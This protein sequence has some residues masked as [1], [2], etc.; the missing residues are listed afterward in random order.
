MPEGEILEDTPP[1]GEAEQR[2]L[3][4][5]V[6]TWHAEGRAHDSPF[7]SA[8]KISATQSYEWLPGERFLVHF[9]QGRRGEDA[10]ACIEIMAYDPPNKAYLVHSFYNDGHRNILQAVEHQGTWT[11][12]GGWR[13][14]GSTLKL[15][16]TSRFEDAG[17]TLASTWEYSRDGSR[18]DCFWETRAVRLPA[19]GCGCRPVLPRARPASAKCRSSRCRS[20]PRS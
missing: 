11:F 1:A 2:L 10:M 9:L 8:A 15:R 6:G 13:K 14:N 17:E 7:G 20:P 19:G 5:F 3:E 12:T 16:C 4:A 18:W